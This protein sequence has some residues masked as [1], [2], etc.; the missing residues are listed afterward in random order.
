MDTFSISVTDECNGCGLCVDLCPL[1]C[2]RLDKNGK[3]ALKYKECW[4]CG[5]CEMECPV[6]CLKIYFPFLLY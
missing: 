4:Y 1:D 6:S 2:L 5:T 3:P